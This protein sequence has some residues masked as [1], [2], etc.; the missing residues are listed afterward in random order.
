ME[1]IFTSGNEIVDQSSQLNISGNII[2]QSWYKSIV[3]ENGK[4]HLTAIVILADIVYWYKPTEIRDEGSGQ[5]VAL[6]KKF[7]ADLLQRSYQ[8]ISDEFGISK[9]EAT[10]AIIFL[11]KLGV[12]QRVFRNLVI[13]G[14]TVTNVLFIELKVERLKE[15]T[16]FSP[17]SLKRDTYK[18]KEEEP[19]EKESD[20][21]PKEQGIPFK[22]GRVSQKKEIPTLLKEELSSH[23]KEIPIYRE[24][25]TNTENTTENN[26][27]EYPILSY[28]EIKEIMKKRIGYD[29]ILNDRPYEKHMLDEILNIIVEVMS[30]KSSTIRVNRE[31]KPTSIVKST[32]WKLDMGSVLYVLDSLKNSGKKAHN[33]RAVMITALYNAS[34]TISSYY[35]NLYAYHQASEAI[36]Q[37]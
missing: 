21:L 17:L 30:S 32:Y 33:I 25:E 31:E 9:K 1:N 16:Y 22:R 15:L 2:P 23:A 24:G 3:R 19:S 4:P 26:N 36:P 5:V 11:E 10:N 37:T 8:Q 12:I 14:I 35:S 7:K 6:K 20:T 18:E 34:M 13:N 27:T 28:Q 29:A